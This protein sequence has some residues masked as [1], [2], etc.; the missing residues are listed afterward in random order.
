MLDYDNIK[1][2]LVQLT[3]DLV[4]NNLATITNPN[5]NTPAVIRARQGGGKPDMP[6]VTVDVSSTILPSGWLLNRY[7]DENDID[8]FEV[9]YEIFCDFRCYGEGSQQILQQMHSLLSLSNTRARLGSLLDTAALVEQGTVISTPD[10]LSTDYQ[11][12]ALL[13]I[14]LYIVDVFQ[15]PLQNGDFILA[16]EATGNL[17][18]GVDG[19]IIVDVDT[20][21]PVTWDDTHFTFDSDQTTFDR[22]E[23]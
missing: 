19:D 16:A 12:G 21:T 18:T 13:T 10:L 3:K 11:E 22:T 4:G 6:F 15:D 20:Q 17:I 5:G 7:F 23:I 1:T 2:Q 14:S 8:T 9:M